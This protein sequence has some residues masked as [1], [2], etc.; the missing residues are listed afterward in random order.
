MLRVRR[1]YHKRF[2]IFSMM[3]PTVRYLDSSQIVL[4]Y[5]VSGDCLQGWQGENQ[6]KSSPTPTKYTVCYLVVVFGLQVIEIF[7]VQV[8]YIL[9]CTCLSRVLNCLL[10]IE[11]DCSKLNFFQRCFPLVILEHCRLIQADLECIE[12]TN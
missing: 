3:Q 7:E 11:F 2:A 4:T 12:N 1:A 10:E 8:V 5:E 9:V 6:V